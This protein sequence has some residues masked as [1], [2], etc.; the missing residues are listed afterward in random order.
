MNRD[1]RYRDQLA[2]L[3]EA[4]ARLANTAP[5][6]AG[7]LAGRTKDPDVE[8]LL[9]GLAYLNGLI[10]ARL[11]NELPTLLRLIADAFFPDFLAPVPAATVVQ[12]ESPTIATL[13]RGL[14]LASPPIEDTACRFR[15]C[16]EVDVGPARLS[17]VDWRPARGEVQL[18]LRFESAPPKE[19]DRW[20]FFLGQDLSSGTVLYHAL[21]ARTLSIEL[22]DASGQVVGP[23]PE[24][25]VVPLGLAAEDALLPV[26]DAPHRLSLLKEYF[27]LPQKLLFVELQGVEAG[28]RRLGVTGPNFGL[29]LRLGL[30]A[31]PDLHLSSS[32]FALGCTPAINVFEYSADPVRRRPL[33]SSIPVRPTGPLGHFDVYRV[34]NVRGHSDKVGWVDYPL[35]TQLDLERPGGFVRVAQVAEGPEGLS[36]LLGDAD[37]EHRAQEEII[38][39]ELLATNGRLAQLL[40]LGELSLVEGAAANLRANNLVPVSPPGAAPKG[41]ARR[42]AVVEHL[43]LSRRSLLEKEA[44]REALAL[45]NFHRPLDAPATRES[46]ALHA[47]QVRDWSTTYRGDPVR[48]LDLELVLDDDA[49]NGEPE[50]Y[51]FASV[52]DEILAMDA[53]INLVSRLT[54]EAL[55]TKRRQRWPRRLGRQTIPG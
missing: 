8:L 35:P 19:P 17:K 45:Y 44:L 52:L 48:G 24:A 32:N 33:Q 26:E 49:F 14:V 2:F 37:P 53:G 4:G 9:E 51:L 27:A 1:G 25:K 55:R 15:S 18:S 41:D 29:R 16:F 39:V 20:R 28:R 50:L 42:R 38:H 47:L 31:A 7:R 43:A 54:V 30:E 23:L 22:L 34:L 40:R 13:P 21:S 3:E 46:E 5:R 12:L 36:L 10:D 11:D 6:V